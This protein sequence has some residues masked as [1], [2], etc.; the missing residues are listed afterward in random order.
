MKF[1]TYEIHNE[2]TSKN[3]FTTCESCEFHHEF[4]MDENHH[5]FVPN[6]EFIVC[7]YIVNF[8]VIA[9]SCLRDVAVKAL[10]LAAVDPTLTAAANEAHTL[11]K[12]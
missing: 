7:E 8:I 6:C 5:E 3:E 1:T 2:F 11:Q 9:T 4:T 10:V 12:Y